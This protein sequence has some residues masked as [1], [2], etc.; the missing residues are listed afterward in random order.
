MDA[1]SQPQTSG[2]VQTTT[3]RMLS[4]GCTICTNR[5]DPRGRRQLAIHGIDAKQ[6]ESLVE[7]DDV[8]RK[9]FH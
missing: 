8:S 7:T 3:V 9:L 2:I 6:W 1:S 4:G 5:H